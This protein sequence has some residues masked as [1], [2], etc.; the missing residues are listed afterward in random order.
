MIDLWIA[1]LA[2]AVVAAS[3]FII[4]GM[5]REELHTKDVYDSQVLFEALNDGC[6][7]AL[8]SGPVEEGKR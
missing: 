8:A 4:V 6:M 1:G 5:M 7:S 2:S 3:A